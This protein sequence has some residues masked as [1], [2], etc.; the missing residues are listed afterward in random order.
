MKLSKRHWWRLTFPNEDAR[1]VNKNPFSENC[2][3]IGELWKVQ[4]HS[5]YYW[6]KPDPAKNSLGTLI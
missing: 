2:W 3:R 6:E 5:M 1:K 4:D